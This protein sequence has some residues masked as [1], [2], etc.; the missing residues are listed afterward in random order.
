MKKKKNHRNIKLLLLLV[1]FILIIIIE[2][3]FINN[4][5]QKLSII[6]WDDKL[7]ENYTFLNKCELEWEK[8]NE[9]VYFRKNL[10]FYYSDIKKIQI[11]LERKKDIQY[12]YKVLIKI[13]FENHMIKHVENKVYSH[14][15]KSHEEYVFEYIE[16]Y[17]NLEDFIK[18][19]YDVTLTAKIEVIDNPSTSTNR[20]INL[21]TKNFNTNNNNNDKKHSV[22]CG[23]TYYYENSHL[24]YYKWWLNINKINGYDKIVLFN[25]SYGNGNWSQ[26]NDL[27]IEYKDLVQIVQFHCLPNFFDLNNKNKTYINFFEIN[28]LYGKNPLAYH[29]HFEFASFN[30]CLLTNRDKYKYVTI[31]D[32]DETI[33]PR[34]PYNNEIIESLYQNYE[35]YQEKIDP[36]SN[37]STKFIPYFESLLTKFN[38]GSKATFGFRWAPYMKNKHIK[39]IFNEIEKIYQS[40]ISNHLLKIKDVNDSNGLEFKIRINGE[41]DFNYAKYLYEMHLKYIEPFFKN[42]SQLLSLVPEPFTRFY[43]FNGKETVFHWWYFKHIHDASEAFKVS[44]HLPE[45]K[46]SS[47]MH[48]PVNYGHVTHFREDYREPYQWKEK[49]IPIKELFFDFV[50]FNNYFKPI[51]KLIYS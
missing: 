38:L 40:N 32:D 43:Y 25:N 6:E 3:I 22:L 42:N 24:N 11:Y 47:S 28:Q 27:F 35:S 13:K 20:A 18:Y 49:E 7:D 1:F 45:N 48:V 4:D 19:K 36:I 21:I 10:A 14:K 5:S 23:K 2:I 30:E 37:K 16:I 50:Y 41:Q 34:K 12:D 46:V 33:I 8:L 29:Q 39:I 17:F 31:M 44:T 26:F 15:L 9:N 51:S